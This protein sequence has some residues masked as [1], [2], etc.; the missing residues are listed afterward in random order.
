MLST[1]F[2][3]ASGSTDDGSLTF[4]DLDGENAEVSESLQAANVNDNF[5]LPEIELRHI[6]K[7]SVRL[8]ESHAAAACDVLRGCLAQYERVDD[9]EIRAL[10]YSKKTWFSIFNV[11]LTMSERQNS[12]PLKLL[13]AALD[14][15]LSHNPF[16]RIKDDLK[17]D[18][19]LRAWQ[20]I[21]G[22]KE[23]NAV[24]PFLQA[25]Q[26]FLSHSSVQPQDVLLAVSR[27]LSLRQKKP[28]HVDPSYCGATSDSFHL[29]QCFEYS[30]VFLCK[31]LAWV[32]Y[33]D[34]ARITGRLVSTFCYSVRTWSLNWPHPSTFGRTEHDD[35]PLWSS[36]LKSFLQS[37]PHQFDLLA[38]HILPEVARQDR[39]GIDSYM[40]KL[41]GQSLMD[42]DLVDLQINILLLDRAIQL[43]SYKSIDKQATQNMGASFLCHA[44]PQIR[45]AA[46]S[47]VINTSSSRGL[48]T[49]NTL[50]ALRLALPSYHAE[51]NT[52]RRQENVSMIK[53]LLSRIS[54]SLKSSNVFFTASLVQ[55]SSPS[56]EPPSSTATI[57]SSSEGHVCGQ[58]QDF[59]AWYYGFLTHEL[60]PTASY[61]RHI[62]SLQIIE[63]LFSSVLNETQSWTECKFNGRRYEGPRCD[64]NDELLISLLDL[65]M[66]PFDDVRDI[67]TLILRK[68]TRIIL[69]GAVS[70]L[71]GQSIK[72]ETLHSLA[73]GRKDRTI[74]PVWL[75]RTIVTKAFDRSKSNM[76]ITG[77]ADHADGFG[78]LY[79]LVHGPDYMSDP[80]GAWDKGPQLMLEDLMSE[81]EQCVAAAQDDLL[82]AV[83]TASLHGYLIATRFGRCVRRGMD[84]LTV[85]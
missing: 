11:F 41:E 52:K 36:A 33:P 43:G 6:A 9:S 76:Q 66:D 75:P 53:S 4:R 8:S 31:V 60:N 3:M 25:L 79:N 63:F 42:C 50:C 71:R 22:Q 17:A 74:I 78:R 14:R 72:A 49:E 80:G 12:K 69:S 2:G 19:S 21:S 18:I 51:V 5:V 40:Q 61:Q 67:A 16:W 84:Q 38:T 45:S 58:Q 70:D 39:K 54:T 46:F 83:Q 20:A 34:T 73:Q 47:L 35:Q 56:G 37:H 24:K 48:L 65:A 23:I 82:L 15:N 55:G 32:K 10:A 1:P 57:T 81:L 68:Y 27:Q 7:G 28:E 62:V 26:L 30:H 85:Q 59:L 13:L 44:S 64:F 77:R 29:S